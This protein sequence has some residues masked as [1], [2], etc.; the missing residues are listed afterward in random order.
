MLKPL[1]PAYTIGQVDVH[2]LCCHQEVNYILQEGDTGMFLPILT[3][4]LLKD[5]WILVEVCPMLFV[6]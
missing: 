1:A 2:G 5:G 3:Q 4:S 6:H